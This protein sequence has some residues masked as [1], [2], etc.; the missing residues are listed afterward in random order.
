MAQAASRLKVNIE[1]FKRLLIRTLDPAPMQINIVQLS[2]GSIA[3]DVPETC[4]LNGLKTL[5][6]EQTSIPVVQQHIMLD[7]SELIGGHK[8]LAELGV[9]SGA[10]LTMVRLNRPEDTLSEVPIFVRWQN[11]PE[12]PKG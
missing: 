8:A 3:L 4:S 10:S 12:S 2:G 1:V 7:T 6:C 9:Q 5:V 11:P